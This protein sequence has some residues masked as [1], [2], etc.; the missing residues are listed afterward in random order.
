[1]KIK[2]SARLVLFVIIMVILSI[3]V[4]MHY[5]Q[6]SIEAVDAKMPHLGYDRQH[7]S[8]HKYI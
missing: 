6:R 5:A 2:K 3:L 7:D 1:M 4:V 8:Q